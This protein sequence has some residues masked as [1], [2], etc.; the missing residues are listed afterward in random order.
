MS[1]QYEMMSDDSRD[2]QIAPQPDARPEQKRPNVG[3]VKPPELP[4]GGKL[5]LWLGLGCGTF[6]IVMSVAVSVGFYG[7]VSLVKTSELEK[8]FAGPPP[9]LPYG[10]GPGEVFDPEN[11]PEPPLA[12]AEPAAPS[13]RLENDDLRL[14]ARW[15]RIRNPDLTS[16]DEQILF[17]LAHLFYERGN[18]RA[19]VQCQHLALVKTGIGRYNLA[20]F[21]AREGDVDA[22]LY[23]L[24]MS[25]R[26]E[27][28]DAAWASRDEDLVG[29]HEDLRW[30]ALLDYLRAYQR[31]WTF[32]HE[33]ATTSREV[34]RGAPTPQRAPADER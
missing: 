2:S 32:I 7:L 17:R 22:A 29:V 34:R 24:Q 25:A 14:V 1:G 26:E 16:L 12:L 27:S 8:L 15:V 6:L 5:L 13:T 19:A 10:E 28:T 21:Y 20:C 9:V 33:Q 23:W 31:Y 18:Y 30:P 11:L 3:R 4:G